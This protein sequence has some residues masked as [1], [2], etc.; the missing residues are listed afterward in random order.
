MVDL[1]VVVMT[2]ACGYVATHIIKQ[3][4]EAGYKVRGTLHSLLDEE[5]VKQL[6]ELCPKAAHELDL[7]ELDLTK[8]E[9]IEEYVF[10]HLITSL[11]SF[12]MKCDWLVST[13]LYMC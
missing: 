13:L 10:Y 7:V 8:E 6:S 3:L 2:E 1:S 4:L 9:S 12:Y 11:G 5:K